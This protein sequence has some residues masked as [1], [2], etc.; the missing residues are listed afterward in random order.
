MSV[1][2][3][4]SQSHLDLGPDFTTRR[5]P[6]SPGV[7][8]FKD[9]SGQILYIGKAKNLKKR[10]SSYFKS[11]SDLPYKTSVVM[12]QAKGLDTLL[13]QT[14]KEALLLESSLVRKH[15]P[16]Y[17]VVL[18]DDKRYPSL[19]L[20]IQS[21]YPRLTIARKIKKDGA[22]YF[23]PYASANAVRSTLKLINT[24][25]QLRKCKGKG[26]PKRSRPCMNFQLGRCL[27]A[28]VHDVSSSSYQEIVHQVRLFLE[29]RNQELIKLLKK[30]MDRASDQLHFEKAARIRDQI[31][32]VEDT[33]E[34]QHVISPKMEDQDVIGL[35]QKDDVFQLV[36]LFL[37]Q[38][39]LQGSRDYRFRIK[40]GS[41]SEITEAFLKQHYSRESFIPKQILISEPIEDLDAITE[42]LS[43]LGGRKITIQRPLRGEKRHLVNLAI[44]NA[45]NL[46]ATLEDPEGEHLM[47]LTASVLN[48]K[49]VLRTIEGLDISN[50]QGQEAVGTIVSFLDGQP[51]RSGYRNYKIKAV[52][53]IDDYGM[54][55][56]LVKR[57]MSRD[58]PPDLFLVDGGKG[59]LKMAKRLLEDGDWPAV[60]AVVSIAKADE[61]RGEKLDKIYLPGR[62]N[63]LSLG[64]DHAVRF[65]MMRIRDE[66]HRRAIAY[67]RKMRG[68]KIQ[69]SAL[70]KI[71]GIGV[72]RRTLLLK[73][74]GGIH[75]IAKASMEEIQALPGISQRLAE[76]IY[77]FFRESR[78][79]KQIS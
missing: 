45:E 43:D 78:R 68:R 46:L 8:L 9:R 16:R 14:E 20:D 73:H 2:N 34:R 13:T 27:G 7:Y 50:I 71:E 60:P 3:P 31:K 52:D 1:T 42:W 12:R 32:A 25:F 51:R 41:G 22:L 65:L 21:P 29:G 54:M 70:D 49:G 77:T 28:C 5:L 58:D 74:F 69:A 30:K 79:E 19:R 6:E 17:N 44:A 59:H 38:G 76:N 23:G 33:I 57:R 62:K 24:I 55:S 18:R 63:P 15:M 53:G 10:L 75:E 56:E 47:E 4:K 37:R 26:L 67:H 64:P 61:K 36:I 40:G 39:Y 11:P 48:F 72:K 66:A 35:S